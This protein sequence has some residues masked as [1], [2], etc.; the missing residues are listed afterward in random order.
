MW[1]EGVQRSFVGSP[2]LCQGLRCLR[3]TGGGGG[4]FV[5]PTRHVLVGIPCCRILIG[6]TIG[7]FRLR[8]FFASRRSYCAQDDSAR[9]EM[10]VAA[11]A[12]RPAGPESNRGVGARLKPCPPTNCAGLNQNRSLGGMA[13]AM[14]FPTSR[15]RA[16]VPH[17]RKTQS[18]EILRW[19]SLALPRTPLPQDDRWWRREVRCPSAHMLV[20]IPLCRILG[21]V[22]I[23]RLR[24]FFASRRSYCAQDDSAREKR[25][26]LR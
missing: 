3:M 8:S 12:S 25:G 15:A 7:I 2:W 17:C 19:E 11:M 24:S 4:K 9:G 26:L 22:G 16:P 14:P 21:G 18:A 10:G 23:F 6:G 5:A 20:G 1:G 13:E